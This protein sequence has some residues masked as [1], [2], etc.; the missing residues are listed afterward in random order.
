M[1]SLGCVESL[2]TK[3]RAQPETS[4]GDNR[5]SARAAKCSSTSTR[6]GKRMT[7]GIT[8][9]CGADAAESAARS[10]PHT[11]ARVSQLAIRLRPRE[12]LTFGAKVEVETRQ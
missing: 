4:S 3:G 1:S 9:P 8:N 12:R 10:W 5:L 7:A 11:A 6:D 2:T